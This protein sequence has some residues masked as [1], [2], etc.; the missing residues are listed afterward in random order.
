MKSIFER[1]GS[2]ERLQSIVAEFYQ[3]ILAD[4]DVNYF[5]IE[6]VSDIAWLHTSMTQ[7]LSS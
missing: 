5:Y 3:N 2:F 1:I 7:Y 4:D 6:N